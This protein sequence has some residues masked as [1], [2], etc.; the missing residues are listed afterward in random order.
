MIDDDASLL[1]RYAQEHAEEAFAEIVRRYLPLVYSAAVRRLGG[2]RHRAAEI[3]QEVFVAL[4]R[5]AEPLSRHA[6]LAAWLH[7]ATRHAALDAL[8]GERR[9]RVRETEAYAMETMLRTEEP[10]AEWERLRP[11]ID[12]VVDELDAA[13]RQAVLLRYF[14]ARAFAEIGAALG[15]SEEAARK[16]VE[17]A[18]DRL[19]GL[20]ERRGIASTGAA[21]ATVLST[22]T[23][24]AAPAGLAASITGVALAGGGLA[25]GALTFMALTKIQ[26]GMAAA[27]VLGGATGLVWQQHGLASAR[28]ESI[29]AEQRLDAVQREN[30]RLAQSQ[31]QSDAERAALR[32]EVEALKSGAARPV[33]P[34]RPSTPGIVLEVSPPAVAPVVPA[35]RPAA[36]ETR[37]QLLQRYAGFFQ[38]RGLSPAQGEQFVELLLRQAE[39]RQD[40]QEAVRQHGLRGGT[41]EVEAM[42]SE[43]YAPITREMRALLGEDGYRAY[44]DYSK[45]SFYRLSFVEPLAPKFA[46]ANAALSAAEAARLV[47]LVAAHHR[48]ERVNATDLGTRSRID[49]AG[50]AQQAPAFLSPAQVA[51]L[52]EHAASQPARP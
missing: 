37:E 38:A 36:G 30:A 6:A 7:T 41:R 33:D 39:V 48:S 47:D 21:L 29:R 5:K 45:S 28:E 23:T 8:R 52:R 16:R 3:A 9:R 49:W 24:L 46:A 40:L 14:Q 19:R 4:A 44:G 50:V 13:D 26:A 15:L 2:D 1:R 42:R 32:A 43:L 25:A 31:A 10:T 51:V 22:Q 17:R 11:V 35:R 34:S 18:L 20:L 27:L 12:D